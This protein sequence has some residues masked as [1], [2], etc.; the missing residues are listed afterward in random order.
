[1]KGKLKV[2]ISS[3]FS[4]GDQIVNARVQ[5]DMW[6][7]LLTEGFIPFAPLW[8]IHQHLFN[9]RRYNEW[10]EWDTEW[11]KVCDCLL[12]LPGESPGGDIE[13]A[14]ARDA[15]IPVFFS[16]EELIKWKYSN[17]SNE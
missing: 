6:D 4:A 16:L 7:K 5:Y 11:V 2:F 9:P 15:G 8:S 10:I 1:M 3:P 14:A 17:Q 12:R 13:V